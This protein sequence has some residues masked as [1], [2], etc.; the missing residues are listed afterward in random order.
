[1]SQLRAFTI[2]CY[3]QFLSLRWFWRSALL[4]GFCVPMFTLLFWK[5]VVGGY[6]VGQA[7]AVHFLA[8]NTVVSLLFGTM[9][10]V[11]SRFAFLQD[12]G[13][14]DYF[15]TLLVRRTALIL[16]VVVAFLCMSLPGLLLALF[17]GTTWLAVPVQPHPLL[18]LA[19]VLGA[20]SLAILGAVVGVYSR[21]PQQENMVRY[22]LTLGLSVLSPVLVPIERL[23]RVLQ[24]TGY[25][26]PTTYA[27]QAVRRA[28]LSQLDVQFWLS[29]LVLLAFCLLEL[30]LVERRLDWRA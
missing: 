7:E 9:G 16:A 21:T 23:P 20:F 12:T 4:G 29:M 17:V 13:A 28:L 5:F 2:L 27:V 1:M 15:A 14:L 30:V 6:G 8:G 18:A 25:L 19:L 22:L 24:W 10:M 26:V 11:G 3:M